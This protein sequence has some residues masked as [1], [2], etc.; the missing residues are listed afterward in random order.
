MKTASIQKPFWY[1]KMTEWSIANPAAMSETSISI[2]IF[3]L[4]QEM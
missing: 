1:K 4:Q 2:Y 3:T